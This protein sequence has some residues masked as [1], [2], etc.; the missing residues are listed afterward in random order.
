[1]FNTIKAHL[2]EP[3]SLEVPISFDASACELEWG[4]TQWHTSSDT[5]DVPSVDY[6][7]CLTGTVK[8]HVCDLFHLF[9]EAELMSKLYEC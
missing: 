3:T 2:D 4:T 9:D 1:M 6:A 5:R 7:L 8:F